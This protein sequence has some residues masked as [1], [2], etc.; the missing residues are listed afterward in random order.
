MHSHETDHVVPESYLAI[1][2]S[3]SSRNFC[4]V[5]GNEWLSAD[6]ARLKVELMRQGQYAAQQFLGAKR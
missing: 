2:S 1:S 6:G 3:R 4:L 5:K